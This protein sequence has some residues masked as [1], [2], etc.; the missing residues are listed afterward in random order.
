[1]SAFNQP[2][3]LSGPFG[4]PLAR[5][6]ALSLWPFAKAI[7]RSLAR[8]LAR[9]P[10]CLLAR[11]PASWLAGKLA[12]RPLADGR[13][14]LA[15]AER[16]SEWVSRRAHFLFVRSSQECPVAIRRVSSWP[17]SSREREREESKVR[18]PM[19]GRRVECARLRFPCPTTIRHVQ[20]R[21]PS[22]FA[23]S[24]RLAS[25]AGSAFS[26][27]L[28]FERSCTCTAPSRRAIRS[29]LCS[30]TKWRRAL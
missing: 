11:S 5:S 3:A 21:H 16:A 1:M 13:R 20:R 14:R 28:S 29:P 9:P 26:L 19:S 25:A 27:S 30:P 8:L 12:R 10:D 7:A 15:V 23:G 6:L 24:A 18:K 4:W 2:N 22:V 17:A